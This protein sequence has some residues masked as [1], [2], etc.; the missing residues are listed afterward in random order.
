SGLIRAVR[1]LGRR[2]VLI[3]EAAPGYRAYAQE[4]RR[5]GED[6]V[7]WLGSLDHHDPLLASAYAAARV[8][9]LP[10]WFETPGLAALEAAL[11]GCAVVVTP[12]G[13]AREYFGDRVEYVRPC[14]GAALA[15]TIERAW[16]V[17]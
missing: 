5:A 9:A 6:Q 8:F 1:R 13:C 3:G 16:K 17:G 14:G 10:S 12:L 11:A 4:C 7:V 2:L 15:R